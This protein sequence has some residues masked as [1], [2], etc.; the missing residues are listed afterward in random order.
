MFHIVLIMLKKAFLCIGRAVLTFFIF[1]FNQRFKLVTSYKLLNTPLLQ[2][3]SHYLGFSLTHMYIITMFTTQDF[4]LQICILTITM[5]TLIL[6]LYNCYVATFYNYKFLCE[7]VPK[8]LYL[9]FFLFFC[10]IYL[11]IYLHKRD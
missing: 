2:P 6:S 10:S 3:S 4:H 5:F 7:R 1:N 8:F 11:A 9:L